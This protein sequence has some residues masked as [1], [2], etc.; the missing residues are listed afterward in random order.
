MTGRD[1]VSTKTKRTKTKHTNTKHS[2]FIPRRVYHA[3]DRT[4]STTP[5]REFDML[6]PGSGF[7]ELIMGEAMTVLYGKAIWIAGSPLPRRPGMTT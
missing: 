1:F 2:A 3:D 7:L 4:C 5:A 6:T